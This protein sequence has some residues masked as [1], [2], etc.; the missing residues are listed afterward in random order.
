MKAAVLNQENKL[1]Q[2]FHHENRTWVRSLEF[3]RQENSF[4]KNRL[5][6]FV[7]Q[8]MDKSIL[9]LAEHFQNQFIIKDEFID[10]LRHDVYEQERMLSDRYIRQGLVLGTD[11]DNRQEKLREQ[12]AYL[13]KD[14]TALRNEFNHY[15]TSSL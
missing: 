2:Q 5:S 11:Y 1:L 7:D 9:A 14:F 15:L 10:Q 4:L 3:F 8:S 6:E 12:M 13:E